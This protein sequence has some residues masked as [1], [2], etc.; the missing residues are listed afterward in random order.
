MG[1]VPHAPRRNAGPTRSG[2]AL[3]GG[4]AL[5]VALFALSFGVEMPDVPGDWH[6]NVA[7]S[8]DGE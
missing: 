6:G 1:G 5:A 2:W 8:A 4:F 7:V 3:L